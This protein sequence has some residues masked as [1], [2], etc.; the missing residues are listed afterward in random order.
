MVTASEVFGA[1]MALMDE[2]SGSGQAQTNDTKEYE[3]RTPAILNMMI[4]E[5]R[6]LTG[7][8]GTFPLV[9]TLEDNV[10]GVED[11]YA[12][13]AM[14]YGL[15]ANLLTDENPTAAAFYQQRYEELRER[16]ARNGE[17]SMGSIENMYG[18]I[19]HGEYA[20]W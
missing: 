8:R 2:L 9:A 6:M 13:S 1:A 14:Q 10:I 16:F 20:R 19:E 7:K 5:Y 17:P 11:G 4:A 18:G 12:L 3:H 15:A